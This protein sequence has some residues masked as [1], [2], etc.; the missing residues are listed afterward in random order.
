[1][2]RM[3]VRLLVYEDVRRISSEENDC[4][5]EKERFTLPRCRKWA[6]LLV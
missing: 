1:M 3:C 4:V 6:I 2:K 5:G